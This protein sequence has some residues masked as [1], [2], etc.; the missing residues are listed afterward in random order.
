MIDEDD[1]RTLFAEAAEAVPPPGRAPQALLD[2]I[3]QEAEAPKRPR[4]RRLA[5][6]AAAAVVAVMAI[7]ML[8]F[9]TEDN[10]AS[11]SFRETGA[12]ISGCGDDSTAYSED[13]SGSDGGVA[14][15]P[16]SPLAPAEGAATGGTG[17]V[18]Q[19]AD[20]AKVIRTGSL[21]LEVREGAFQSTVERITAQTVGLGGY[22]AEATT[23]ESS[24]SPSG[25]IT[26]RVP[27]ESFDQL[28]TDLRK[29]GDVKAV[30]SKGTDVTAQ[31]TDL[32]ARETALVAT[33]DR[34][35]AVL[36]EA[37]TVTDILA[38]QDRITAVQVE[39]E[40][41]KGQQQLLEDQTAFGTLAITLGEPGA[42]I[43]EAERAGDGGL[44]GAW[45]DA[46]RRFGDN[47]ETIVSWSGSAAVALAVG[48]G[49]LLL[50]RLVWVGA[51][52]RTV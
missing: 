52:R 18:G 20:T 26:V 1:L 25:S 13:G 33:R 17:S 38:V 19:A 24:D 12:A 45:D 2:A 35:N 51:R 8:G 5:L 31:F 37:D 44:G 49:V 48:L 28:L 3:A 30:A 29:L 36:A 50:V 6:A 7:G 9:K 15:A 32:A 16:A 11:S 34:L 39:I 4:P 43:I 14:S 40:L 41:V 46:R 27:G 47:I 21:D 23:S 42:E 10:D 22:I